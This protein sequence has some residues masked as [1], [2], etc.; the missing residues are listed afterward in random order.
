MPSIHPVAVSD[1]DL[2][3]RHRLEMFRAMGRADSGLGQMIETFRHWLSPR[4]NAGVYFGFVAMEDEA[5][6]GGVGLLELDWPP[7]PAHP[8]D[9]RRGYVCNLFVEPQHRGSGVARSLMT[10]S[11]NEFKRRGIR[12]AV[13]H[14]SAAGRPL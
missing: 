5:A 7:H 2:I 8:S 3:C 4:L 10:E 6:I 11:E 14:A 1:L 12:F 9:A 13:L